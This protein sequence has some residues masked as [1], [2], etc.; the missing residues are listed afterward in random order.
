MRGSGREH[1]RQV[2][3]AA[4]AHSTVTFN[5]ASSARFVELTTFRRMLGGSPIIGGPSRVTVSREDSSEMIV[6]RAGH[7]GYARRFGILHERVLMLSTDGPRVHCEHI[8]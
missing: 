4:A 6:L 1:W 8:F 3:R 2:A 7:D 5:D